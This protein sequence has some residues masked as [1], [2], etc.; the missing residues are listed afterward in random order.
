MKAIKTFVVDDLHVV[1][2]LGH[3]TA[4]AIPVDSRVYIRS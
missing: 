2:F 3:L 1:Y 4:V